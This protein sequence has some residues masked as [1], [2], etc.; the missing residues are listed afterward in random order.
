MGEARNTHGEFREMCIK[1]SHGNCKIRFY[2]Y[3]VDPA[4]D[5]R[6]ILRQILKE[7]N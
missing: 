5:G 3:L 7:H 1:F 2:A 6:L 4:S